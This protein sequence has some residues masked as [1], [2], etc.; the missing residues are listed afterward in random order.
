MQATRRLWFVLVLI[1]VAS[2]A[3]LGLMGR[4]ILHQAP[5]VPSRM[6]SADGQVLFTSKDVDEGRLAWQSMGGQQV[7]SIW[8]H[9]AYVAPDWSA[10]FLHR[11]STALLDIWAMRESRAPFDRLAPERQAALKARLKQEIR[12]NTYDARTGVIT[13]SA[14]RGEAIRRTQV[15]YVAL[16]GD[17]PGLEKLRS[18]YAIADNAVPDAHRR[19]QIAS[20]FAWTAWAAGTDRPNSTVTYTNNWPHERLIDNGPSAASVVWS[21]ASVMLLILGI[22]ALYWHHA[23]TRQDEHVEAPSADPLFSLKP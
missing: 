21:I 23:R 13:V 4:E 2:F 16:L 22:A 12:F 19:A 5:P 1:L 14:D 10:D 3:A 18:D 15:H 8:G 7:G 17:D 20:Y 6:V 11:Q 9:G